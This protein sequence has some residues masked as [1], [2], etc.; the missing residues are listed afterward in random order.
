M[1]IAIYNEGGDESYG[2]KIIKALS[3]LP[4]YRGNPEDY[5][6]NA[7]GAFYF[8]DSN[9]HIEFKYKFDPTW[10]LSTPEQI[11]EG[12]TSKPTMR[13]FSTGAT[14]NIDNNK[15]DFE[16][17][18]SPIALKVFAEYM[19]KNRFQ[20]DGEMRD[21]DNWQKGIPIDAYMK[22]MYRHFFDVWST[23]RGVVTP[24]DQ[25]SNL[26]GLMFNVQGMLHELLKQQT[27]IKIEED[28]YTG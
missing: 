1:K 18:L 6:G 10:S 15:L 27:V 22:S 12:L 9:G 19:H 26:C 3:L 7:D 28:E 2:E 24:E 23:H 17:F 4:E 11:E 13:K 21:S 16:G 5:E 20:A 14:R 25:I 8:L